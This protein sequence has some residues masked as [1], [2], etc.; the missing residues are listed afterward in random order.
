M[1]RSIVLLLPFAIC[2]TGTVVAQPDKTAVLE[3]A[4]TKFEKDMA[5]SDEILLAGIDKTILQATKAGNKATQEK[6][7]YERPLFVTQHIMPT[8]FP[9]EGYLQQRSKATAALLAVYQ[10][11]IT[12]LTKAK[13]FEEAM[14]IED[15]LNEVLKASRGYGLAL[16]DLET[17]PDIMFMI[18][19][20][21]SGLV[22]DT[23]IDGGRGRLV[24]T[25]KVGKN[26]PSQSWRLEREEKGFLIRNVKS[27]NYFL[28]PGVPSATEGAILATGGFDRKN[29]TP[30]A[31][32]FRLNSIRREI[33]IEPSGN[34]LALTPTEKKVKGVTTIYVT[35][36]KKE[37]STSAA[38]IWKFVE[39]K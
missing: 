4:K 15:N 16:P 31:Y 30:L 22:V 3:K 37:S 32:L 38:Q 9:S 12:E 10:P 8:A 20:K 11:A 34:E 26:K 13:K 27:K 33:T 14:A 17:H 28:V 21:D 23:E 18:E 39:V 24:L 1:M 2:L 19:N 6:L 35:P 29:E 36:E 7:T 25:T 5:K